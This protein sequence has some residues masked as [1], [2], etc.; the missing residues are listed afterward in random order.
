MAENKSIHIIDASVILKWILSD[1]I[2]YENALRILND[3]VDREIILYIPEHTY[4]EVAN[5]LAMKGYEDIGERLYHFFDKG[6]L[7]SPGHTIA[8]TKKTTEIM[9]QYKGVSFYDATYHA[10]AII[11]H[12]TFITADA[13]YYQ[14]TKKL[15]HSLLLQDYPT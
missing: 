11:R 6:L 4:T 1:E 10:M 9:R 7:M 2:H 8:Q 14:K 5:I 12:G 3:A 13:K 15:G